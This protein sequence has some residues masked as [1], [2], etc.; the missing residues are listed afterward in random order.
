MSSLSPLGGLPH[1]TL[2]AFREESSRGAAVRVS[3]DG[4]E[5][6]V[7]AEGRIEGAS[8]TGRSVAWVQDDADTTSMFVQALA[9]GFGTRLSAA[10]AQEL[11]LEPAPGQPLASRLVQQALDMAQAGRQ[12]LAGVDFLTQIE[13]SAVAGGAAFTRAAEA[14]G[15]DPRGLDADTRMLLDRQLQARFDAAAAAGESPVPSRTVSDWVASH[16]SAL[17]APPP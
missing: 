3:V 8:G 10:V 2:D 14:A 1:P 12:A 13:H 7:L 11:G 4:Q 9:Q 16:L 5:F 17:N 6:S 15:L